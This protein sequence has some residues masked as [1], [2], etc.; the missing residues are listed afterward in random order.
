V[1]STEPKIK[2]KNTIENNNQKSPILLT[3]KAFNAA[4]VACV[5]VVQKLIKRKEQMPIPSQ[6]KK[7]KTKLSEVTKTNIKKVNKER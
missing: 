3:I 4:F 7:N 2:N 1:K 6:P 5:L